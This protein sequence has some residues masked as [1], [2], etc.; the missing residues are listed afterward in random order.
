M[1]NVLKQKAKCVPSMTRQVCLAKLILQFLRC[2]QPF[3]SFLCVSVHGFTQT[4]NT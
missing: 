3:C 1:L 2:F 4:S